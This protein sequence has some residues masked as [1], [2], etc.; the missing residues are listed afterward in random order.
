MKWQSFEDR[1][2]ETAQHIWG[3]PCHPRRVGGVNLDG[4]LKL[5]DEWEIFV[6]MTENRTL[7]KVREDVTKLITARMA[8][9]TKGVSA[10]CYCVVNGA[11]TQAMIDAGKGQKIHVVS[12][13]EFSKLLFDFDE[14]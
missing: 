11:V 1:V 9:F 3:R 7:A 12:V 8:A 4:H 6:E 10:R 2:R 13:G 5:A 14:Y